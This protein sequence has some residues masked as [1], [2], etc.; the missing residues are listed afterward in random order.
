MG[1]PSPNLSIYGIYIAPLKGNYSEALP[2]QAR[3]KR[4][5]LRRLKNELE[6]SRGRE[7]NS[8]ERPFH[9]CHES[10]KCLKYDQIKCKLSEI[11][12]TLKSRTPRSLKPSTSEILDL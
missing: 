10:L 9:Y 1:S 11:Q 5:A 6:K 4:K 7:R 8:R 2:A 3:A 12:P